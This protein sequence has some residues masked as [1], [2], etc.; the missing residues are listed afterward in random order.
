MTPTSHCYFDYYQGDPAARAAR[1]SAAIVPLSKVYSFEPVP[2]ALTAEEGRFILGAQGNL[3]TEYIATPAARR[4][5]DLPA[6]RGHGRGGLDEC[7]RDRRLEDFLGRMVSQF[8]RYDRWA[9]A[10]PAASMP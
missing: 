6:H 2:A 3:W 9:S 7:R 10:T 1:A 8:R 5:H 4:V